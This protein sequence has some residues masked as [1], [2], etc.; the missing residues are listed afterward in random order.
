MI[1]SR[2]LEYFQAVARELHF[3]RAAGA[4]RIAQPALSQQIRKL[5]RQLGVVLFERDNHRVA[6]TEAGSA[7]L[8]R[9]DRILSDLGAVEDEMRGWAGGTRGRIRL[10]VA[11]GLISGMSRL[12][13]EF[14]TAYPGIE[15][16]F[17]EMTTGEM[18]EGLLAGQLDV[19]TV[20]EVPQN[21]P[22][23]AARP[24][25]EEPLVL[26]VAPDAPPRHATPAALTDAASPGTAFAPGGQARVAEL[27]DL[28]LVTYAAGSVVREVVAGAL[29]DA[30]VS[31][32][33]RFET[34]DYGTARSLVSVGLAAAVL[35]RSVATEPGPP[36]RVIDLE[37]VLT[38]RPS[39]AWSAVRVPTPALKAFVEFVAEHG[40]ILGLSP[41][42]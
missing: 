6:L 18:V 5:E 29:A 4:L 23:L 30:G 37:P 3:T 7:L 10:G 11:R 22:R 34:R 17:R 15:M 8:E 32:R 27:G 12:L 41:R 13:A 20:A 9:A 38:W 24:L 31:G 36:V 35:P 1:S 33:F 21:E 14:C 16:R 25:G 19:A 28:D 39:L 42:G 26:I 2:Q 40:D